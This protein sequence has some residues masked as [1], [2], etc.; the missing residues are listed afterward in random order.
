MQVVTKDILTVEKGIICQQV[1]CQGAMGSGIAKAIRDKWPIVYESYRDYVRLHKSKGVSVLG[2]MD[3][4]NVSDYDANDKCLNNKWVANL[5]GQEFYG[6]DGKQ[7]TSYEAFDNALSVLA[8]FCIHK[9]YPDVYFPYLI[10]C[11]LGGGDWKIVSKMIEFYFP[12]AII[13]KLSK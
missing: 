4:V 5:F 7:Y 12:N 1:N 10:G 6:N 3:A 8:S 9:K 13:C 2:N 11:G